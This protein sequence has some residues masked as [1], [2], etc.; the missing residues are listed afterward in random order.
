MQQPFQIETGIRVRYTLKEAVRIY[1]DL[2]SQEPEADLYY[3][4]NN[5]QLEELD[6]A[7][8]LSEIKL[9]HDKDVAELFYSNSSYMPVSW[10]PWGVYYNRELFIRLGVEEPVTPEDLQGLEKKAEEAGYPLYSLM[11]KIK[12]PAAL[13]F[14]YLDLQINGL[15][16]S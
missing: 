16:F 1:E 2:E 12:W 14:D 5:R 3:L 15:E 8:K 11:N 10:Y 7:G 13:L 6:K 9:R 4:I